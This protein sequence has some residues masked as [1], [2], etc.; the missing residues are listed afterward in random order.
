MDDSYRCMAKTTTYKVTQFSHSVV[1][2]SLQRHGLQ[3]TMP[4][5]PSPTPGVLF[6]FFFELCS[7][8]LAT[9]IEGIYCTI[10]VV[11]DYNWRILYSNTDNL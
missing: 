9:K 10:W 1:S 6:F 8:L 3:H 11:I 4:P 5:C 2:N 7:P